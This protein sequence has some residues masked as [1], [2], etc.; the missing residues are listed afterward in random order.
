MSIFLLL[1][2]I[3]FTLVPAGLWLSIYIRRRNVLREL[4]REI[5]S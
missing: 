2:Y 5:Y 4:H 1:A 3:I